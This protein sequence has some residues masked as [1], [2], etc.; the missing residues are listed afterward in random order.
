MDAEQL[1]L[2]PEEVG[3]LYGWQDSIL[4]ERVVQAVMNGIDMFD[5]V[6]TT[7]NARNGTVFIPGGKLILKN[8]ANREDN[9]PLQK[10]CTCYTCR[11]FSRSYLRHLFKTREI[12]GYRLSSIH[13]LH[14]IINFVEKLRSSIKEGR[15][16]EFRKNYLKGQ[17]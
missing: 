16:E 10:D 1:M 2:S 8:S 3:N 5:S 11:N 12:L 17:H 15:V 9:G 7:R 6:L 13:N 14:Y 4:D